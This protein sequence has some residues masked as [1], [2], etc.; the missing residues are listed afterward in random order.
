[1][2]EPSHSEDRS[3][4]IVGAGAGAA[5]QT[6]S[7][8]APQTGSVLLLDD[9]AV[10]RAALQRELERDGY[11]TVAV[12]D[13]EAG[14]AELERQGFEA[15]LTDL[16]MPGVDGIEFVRRTREIDPNVV[17]IV[18][19][20]FGST[21]RSIEALEAGAFW[22][23]DKNYDRLS[24][25]SALLGKALEYRQLK[26]SNIRLQRQLETRY[27]FENIVGESDALRDT[28]TIVRKVADTEANVLILGES[29]TGKELIARAIHYNSRRTDK[30]FVA[31]NCGAIPEELL[32]SELF[33]HMRGAFTGAIRDHIGR[34]AA[35]QGGTLF[36]DEIGDMSLNLQTKLLRVL[37]EREFQ[38]V[39]SSQTETADV[40]IVA[41]TNQDLPVLIEERR[42]R[43]DLYFRLNVVPILVPSLRDRREDI[44]LLIHHFV[45]QNQS[46]YPGVEGI[47]EAA[48]K[49][50]CEYDWPGNVRELEGFIERLIVLRDAGWI[51]ENDIPAPV[52]T[53]QAR[54]TTTKLPDTGTDLAVNVAD[55][56]S[57]LILQALERTGWNKN[58]A[59]KLLGMKRT[60]LVEKIRSRGLTPPP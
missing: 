49:H 56:E 59:A 23:I 30:P 3:Q 14:L 40:R 42:F 48:Q 43:E 19:T 10:F 17:C 11:Q 47:T 38:R 24:A 8:H 45:R 18:V 53:S 7:A 57:D 31:V 21:E 29:G 1:M 6:I 4:P 58:Q 20:G 13:A 50:L 60:T 36:L 26:R 33:G 46:R 55:F 9:D 35:A 22:F 44:P 51:D 34:F 25:F 15:I 32:E 41:A 16:R 27:G 2:R 28:L 37:Q 5:P 39:G 52:R 54:R 12:S